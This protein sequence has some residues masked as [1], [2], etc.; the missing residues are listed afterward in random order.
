MNLFTYYCDCFRGIDY[1]TLVLGIIFIGLVCYFIGRVGGYHD[2]W[3]ECGKILKERC[4][5]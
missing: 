2:G 1:L 4:I 5:K 3:I